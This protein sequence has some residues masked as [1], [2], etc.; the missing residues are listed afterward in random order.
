MNKKAPSHSSKKN[1]K[2]KCTCAKLGSIVQIKYAGDEESQPVT[3]LIVDHI[4]TSYDIPQIEIDSDLGKA[5]KG[6]YA[7]KDL[8][9]NYEDEHRG[10]TGIYLLKAVPLL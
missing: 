8:L 1:L 7:N 6:K 3:Y 5:I 9:I 4:N 10:I 2:D